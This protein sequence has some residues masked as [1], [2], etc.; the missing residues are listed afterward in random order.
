[1]PDPLAHFVG[2]EGIIAR[3]CIA[4]DEP[5]GSEAIGS[6]EN[7]LNVRR[8]GVQGN[9][10]SCRELVEET[11]QPGW[12]SLPDLLS[13]ADKSWE[14]C[15]DRGPGT[16]KEGEPGVLH[17]RLQ[18]D[19]SILPKD[20]VS[21]RPAEGTGKGG[22]ARAPSRVGQLPVQARLSNP[23]ASATRRS[24]PTEARQEHQRAG[25]FLS[26]GACDGLC[27]Y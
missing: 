13:Q 6:R 4:V 12:E 16:E 23:T 22:A 19:Y 2:Q 14:A 8:R 10:L 27:F 1:M 15:F 21:R 7:I 17:R 3:A 24:D 11:A 20:G 9:P 25:D 18:T 26:H 5:G